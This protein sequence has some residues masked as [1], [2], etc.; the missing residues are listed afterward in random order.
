[1]KAFVAFGDWM[2][3]LVHELQDPAPEDLSERQARLRKVIKA[4]AKEAIWA[5]VY[6]LG[7]QL[8][9]YDAVVKRGLLMLLF[10]A[11]YWC[12]EPVDVWSHW[13]DMH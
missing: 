4:R 13:I 5:Y 3:D 7:L 10:L 1:M 6:T 12:T 8:G 2:V 11:T 9:I